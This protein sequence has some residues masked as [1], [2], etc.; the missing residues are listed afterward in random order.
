LTFRHSRALVAT[1]AAFGLV[2]SLVATAGLPAAAHA[3]RPVS[4]VFWVGHPSGELHKTIVDEVRMFNAEHPSIHVIMFNKYATQEGIA[5]FLTHKAPN[6]AEVYTDS[7]Q[8]FIDA[9]AI[10]DLTPYVHSQQGFT[11]AEIRADYYP[12]IW[13]DMQSASG[14]Q[15]LMPLEKKSAV[16]IYYNADLF[17]RAH[18]AEPPKTWA[19]LERDATRITALGHGIHGI[20]WTPSVRQFYVLTEDF[21]GHVWTNASQKVFDLN[22]AGA[23]DALSYLRTM[24]AKQIMLISSGYD[25]Q[26]AFGTGKIGMLIDASAGYTYDLGSAGGKFPM[27]AAP[28]PAGPSG[29]AYNYIN[30]GSLVMFKT[31]TAAQ[32]NAA[33]TFMKWISS[34][35]TNSYWDMH[36][37]YLPLGPATFADMRSFYKKTPAYRA[38]FTDP[39]NWIIKPPYANYQAAKSAMDADFLKGLRGQESVT[40][41]LAA[42]TQQGNS[43][44][45][46]KQRL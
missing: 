26:L 35:A 14:P 12:A 45:Q 46:G 43:F 34:P 15:Y 8:K 3:S 11:P 33:W 21:G 42:M 22:N 13:K 31:G 7:A 27:L 17:K 37:N 18:I 30:G 4:I 28:A 23:R 6:V 38:S 36:T 32:R 29:K 9:G 19:Q 39:D 16:V 41:A 40:A 20:D 25:Y 2:G 24:V 44:M 10:V 1:T 5:A